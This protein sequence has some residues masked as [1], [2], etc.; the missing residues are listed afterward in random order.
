MSYLGIDLGTTSLK[1]VL[2]SVSG[3]VLREG[4]ASYAMQHP[5]PGAAVQDPEHWWRATRDA[6]QQIQNGIG[7]E[8]NAIGLS[9][10]MHG[11]VCLNS[12][13]Q[14]I[15]PALIWPDT[16]GTITAAELTAVVGEMRLSDTIGTPLASGFQGVTVAW[17]RQ[18]E[19]TT[20]RSIATVLL[21]KDYL[22][23]RLTGEIAT[24]PSDAAGTG[25]L[26]VH[27]R[28][29]SDLMLDT[30]GLDRGKV[31]AIRPS[32]Q[33]AGRLTSEAAEYLGL[34][35]G[36]PVV[37]GGGDAP[38]AALA[39]GVADGRSL[40]AT[41]SSGAQVI[42]F[43]DHP[44]VDPRLRVHTFAAPLDPTKGEAGW[45]VMGAT[46][47]AGM[48]LSWLKEN[49]FESSSDQAITSMVQRASEISPGS[50]G[51]LFAPYLTGE[52]TPA[53]RFASP[54]RVP[55]SDC[56]PRPSPPDPCGNGRRRLRASRCT[57][58]RAVPDAHGARCRAG[59]RRIAQPALAADHGRH[60][61]DAGPPVADR[62]PVGDRR[63]AACGCLRSGHDCQFARQGVGTV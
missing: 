34:P 36:L 37:T 43:T 62:R 5:Y 12:M 52:R 51:L 45:Y 22:R 23:F 40:L 28:D 21:P 32:A 53:P 29:W 13:R 7:A 14:L 49:I 8:I 57:R 20:W 44:A 61:R 31:P 55:W 19:P 42:A 50:N 38:L 26:D 18:H 4:T 2:V 27:T 30:V 11:T 41:L 1:A 35:V 54:G 47:V 63:G 39:S 59:R 17:L 3:E 48:A 6:V 46:M 24:D 15:R 10:Q 33:I 16:R 9:G 58:C 60:L 56:G 25:M